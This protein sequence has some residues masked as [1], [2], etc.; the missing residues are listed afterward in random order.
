LVWF[1][2]VWDGAVVVDGRKNGKDERAVPCEVVF[3]PGHELLTDPDARGREVRGPDVR[4]KEDEVLGGAEVLCCDD[5]VVHWCGPAVG[6]GVQVDIPALQ[7]AQH[8]EVAVL[9]CEVHG[10]E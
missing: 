8:I 4:A 3:R 10:V 6:G 7:R 5:C 1:S 2:A 9:G